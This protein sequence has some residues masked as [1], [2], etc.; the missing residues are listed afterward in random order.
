MTQ[1]AKAGAA[2][3]GPAANKIQS[4]NNWR[5]LSA[6]VRRARRE[7]RNRLEASACRKRTAAIMSGRFRDHDGW[8]DE[9]ALDAFAPHPADGLGARVLTPEMERTELKAW[10]LIDTAK[11]EGR[12]PYCGAC[13][14]YLDIVER[15]ERAAAEPPRL[16]MRERM[17][18]ARR[19][20]QKRNRRKST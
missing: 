16:S 9:E 5:E 2:R 4:D 13:R 10:S 18:Q 20:R 1:N 8:T 15:I 19:D 7:R 3:E 6:I 17:R 11:H 14:A 12:E